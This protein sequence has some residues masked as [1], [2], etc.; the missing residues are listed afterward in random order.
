MLMANLDGGGAQER[1][2]SIYICTVFLD[3]DH[4]AN[5]KL[6]SIPDLSYYILSFCIICYFFYFDI[7]YARKKP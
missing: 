7:L 5:V 3:H 6:S 2:G 1:V 4:V